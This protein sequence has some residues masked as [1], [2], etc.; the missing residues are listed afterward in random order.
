MP[1]DQ[2]RS[3][4]KCY[5]IRAD[6]GSKDRITEAVYADYNS[7]Y[8]E[9]ERYY[10]DLCCSDDRIYY[11]IIEIDSADTTGNEDNAQATSPSADGFPPPADRAIDSDLPP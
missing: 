3:A 9:L 10:A 6:D 2:C 5:R 11:Q 1:A 7:A 4:P 8:A